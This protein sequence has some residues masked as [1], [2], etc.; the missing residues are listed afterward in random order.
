MMDAEDAD[1]ESQYDED[2]DYTLSEDLWYINFM[3]NRL[4][5]IDHLLILKDILFPLNLQLF[6]LL[7]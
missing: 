3:V 4:K 1:V 5:I 6:I 7:D 2:S